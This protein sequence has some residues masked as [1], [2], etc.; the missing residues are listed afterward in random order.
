MKKE[1]F[2]AL[3]AILILSGCSTFGGWREQS[4]S[5]HPASSLEQ[6]INRME[7]SSL[8]V[9]DKMKIADGIRTVHSEGTLP[10][11]WKSE[12]GES[13]SVV[14]QGFART[15]DGTYCMTASVEV[16]GK[17]FLPP[18]PLCNEGGVWTVVPEIK[19]VPIVVPRQEKS[20]AILPIEERKDETVLAIKAKPVVP[21]HSNKVRSHPIVRSRPVAEGIKEIR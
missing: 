20:I 8:T 9:K 7:N 3:L 1:F 5:F 6:L 4:V 16:S 10:D 13:L 11:V 15:S 21:L 12:K 2:F 17:E 14:H 19:S 18:T